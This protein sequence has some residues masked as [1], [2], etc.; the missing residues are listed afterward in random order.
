[1][2]R[3]K[4]RLLHDE[5]DNLE[6][7][8]VSYADFITL[9]FAFFVV[10]YALSTINEG[11]YRVLSNSIVRAFRH[12]QVN[13]EGQI[14][15]QTIT[16]LPKTN[17]VSKAQEA[18]KQKQ[19]DKMRNMAKEIIAVMAPLIEQGKVRVLETSRGVSVEINDSVLFPPGQA[20][21]QAPLA[22]A[23]KSIADVLVTA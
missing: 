12:V 10:M 13:T 19:R 3:R 23:M 20:V 7:W 14:P 9:L 16:P 8:M 22:K 5:H 6:R 15:A 11:K 18:F 17:L 2:A 4:N 1:M 21:L